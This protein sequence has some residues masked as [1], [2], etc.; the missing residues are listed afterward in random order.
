MNSARGGHARTP[1]MEGERRGRVRGGRRR[2][3][4]CGHPR[5]TAPTMQGEGVRVRL[6]LRLVLH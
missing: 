1:Q 2:G 6:P 3:P 4:R 5:A